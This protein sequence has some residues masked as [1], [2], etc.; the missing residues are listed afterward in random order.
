M[1]NIFLEKSYKKC[2]GKTIP[3]A[4]PKKT[5]LS[6]SYDQC[7][8]VLYDDFFIACQVEGYWNILKLSRRPLIVT[9]SIA[10]FKRVFENM[11]LNLSP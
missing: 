3:D 5:K 6:N 11:I 8:K 9:S 4:F 10:F 2:D 1:E 7:S